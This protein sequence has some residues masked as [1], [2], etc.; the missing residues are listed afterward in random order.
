[1]RWINRVEAGVA[2]AQICT[3]KVTPDKLGIVGVCKANDYDYGYDDDS[4][5]LC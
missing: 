5:V 1:M 3:T 2:C 4:A